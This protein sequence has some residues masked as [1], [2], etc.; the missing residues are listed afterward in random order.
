MKKRGK[1]P[2]KK[3][4][5]QD[6]VECLDTVMKQQEMEDPKFKRVHAQFEPE[7]QEITKL[8]KMILR[9]QDEKTETSLVEQIA[10]YKETAI[11]PLVETLLILKKMRKKD[12]PK[13]NV[14]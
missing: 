14:P 12:P 11:Y 3:W 8:I 9:T 4:T 2:D 13:E 6:F 7:W 5:E 10:S 1:K